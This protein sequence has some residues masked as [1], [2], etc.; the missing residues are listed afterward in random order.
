MTSSGSC[1]VGWRDD[2][3]LL[4]ADRDIAIVGGQG[5]VPD[6]DRQLRCA[7]ARALVRRRLRGAGVGVEG[8]QERTNDRRC[9]A[10]AKPIADGEED[11]VALRPTK[12]FL[13]TF[14]ALRK[15]QPLP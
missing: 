11:V 3:A 10:I 5:Q 9:L 1:Q 2:S 15:S 14:A 7:A 8:N 6:R 12:P 4:V 13:E